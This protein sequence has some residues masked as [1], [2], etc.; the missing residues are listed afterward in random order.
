MEPTGLG[1]RHCLIP[2]SQGCLTED[3]R[4][5]AQPEK[6]ATSWVF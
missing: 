3:M 6:A 5:D 4:I 1:A 2:L